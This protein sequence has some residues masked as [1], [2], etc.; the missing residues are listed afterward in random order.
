MITAQLL[1]IGSE[2]FGK[3]WRIVV[4]YHL[5]EGPKRFSEIK[6]LIPGCSVK[7][8]SEVLEEMTRNNLLDRKQYSTIPVKVTYELRPD[9][10]PLASMIPE[11]AVKLETYLIQ[12]NHIHKLPK[13]LLKQLRKE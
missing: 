2:L 4:A 5:L 8:L 1:N 6:A 9:A 10:M 11:Y 7:V 13:E 12:N 3:K